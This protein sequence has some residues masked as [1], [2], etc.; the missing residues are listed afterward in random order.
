M[1][2]SILSNVVWPDDSRVVASRPSTNMS[3]SQALSEVHVEGTIGL[4]KVRYRVDEKYLHKQLSFIK[5]FCLN[6]IS[7]SYYICLFVSVFF[8][9]SDRSV[10]TIQQHNDYSE[11]LFIGL[12]RILQ[13]SNTL[14]PL[15]IMQAV[16]D[17][18]VTQHTTTGTIIQ[19][20]HRIAVIAGYLS[21]EVTGMS[22]YDYVYG[23]DLEYTLKAQKLS[24]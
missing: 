23:E 15:T 4:T 3:A 20:D 7:I 8:L 24:K 6:F 9:V 22:A 13:T 18:Y 11:P 17:E 12:V 19:T 14:P 5:S 21:G 16:Q 10:A 1:A 2:K